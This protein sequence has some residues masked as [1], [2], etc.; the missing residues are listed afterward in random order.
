MAMMLPLDLPPPPREPVLPGLTQEE[1][2]I[3]AEEERTLIHGIDGA[4]LTPFLFQQWTGKRLT[5]SFGW[6]YD[7][8]TG[9]FGPCEP[10]PDWAMTAR[11][12]AARFA[13]LAPD[14]LE[15]MLLIRY[16]PGAGIGWHRDRPAFEHVIGISLGE[17]AAMRFRRR[18]ETGFSRANAMLAPRSIYHMSGQARHDWEHSIAPVEA[19]RWS[20]TFRSLRK[21]PL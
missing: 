7:F 11:T 16:D 19:L 21:Q 9:K 3:T 4:G 13:G 1:G 5:K 20:I 17:P 2:F 18:T 15:Q 8:Q 12:R 6:S 10:I 14:E